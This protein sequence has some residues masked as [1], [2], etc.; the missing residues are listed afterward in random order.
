MKRI[1]RERVWVD[2]DGDWERSVFMDIRERNKLKRIVFTKEEHHTYPASDNVFVL[3]LMLYVKRQLPHMFAPSD[4]CVVEVY[5][6]SLY[7][8]PTS[9]PSL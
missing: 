7:L 6:S 2:R 3:D 4:D 9:F 5:R 8:L 1:T